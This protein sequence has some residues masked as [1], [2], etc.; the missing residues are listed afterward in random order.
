MSKRP[1][2]TS[3]VQ[4]GGRSSSAVSFRNNLPSITTGS[5]GGGASRGLARGEMGQR[6]VNVVMCGCP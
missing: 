3:A 2:T 6:H 5:G 4:G 1:G